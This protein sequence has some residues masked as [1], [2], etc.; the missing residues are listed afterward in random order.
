MSKKKAPKGAFHGLAGSSFAQKKKVVLGNVKHSG[1]KKDIFLSN[2]GPSNS[3]YSNIDSLSGN[4]KN[5]GMA[6]VHD[7]SLLGLAVT[8]S[9]AKHININAVFGSSLGSPDFTIDNNEIIFK[10]PVEVSVKK[11]FALNIDI[12]A[13]EGKSV[14]A[15]TQLVR[16]NFSTINGFGEAT[17]LSKFEEIIR[18][19]FTSE[20]SMNMTTLLARKK[21]IS[22]NTDLKKQSIYSDQ[23]VVIKEIPMDMPKEM[24]IAVVSKFGDIKSIRVQLIGMW[25]KAI[26]EFASSDQ[27]EQL[28]FRWSFLIGKNF[29]HASR[30]QFRTLLFTL[31][32]RTMAHDLGT[33]LDRAGGKTCV[34]NYSVGTGNKIRCAVIG[35]E[36]EEDLESAYCIEPIFSGIKLSWARID[37]VWCECCGKFGHSVLKCDATITSSFKPVKLFKKSTSEV[38]HLR[39]VKLYAKKNVSISHSTAFGNRSWAQ[40]VLAASTSHNHSAKAGSGPFPIVG[41][42]SNGKHSF[43]TLLNSS[44]NACLSTLECSLKLLFNQVSDIVKQLNGIALVS[45]TP[46]LIPVLFAVVDS[47][48]NLDMVLDIPDA[49]SAF[50]FPVANDASVLNSSNTRVLTSKVGSLES[51]LVALETSVGSVLGKLDLLCASLDIN[52]SAKQEDAIHWHKKSENMVL[53]IMET[54]LKLSTRPWIM[55]KGVWIFSSGLDKS[56]FGAGVAV[57]MNNSLAHHVSKVKEVSS[58]LILVW[59]LFKGKLL[60]TFVSLYAGVSTKVRFGLALEINSLIAKVVNSNSFVVLGEDF[61]KNRSKKNASNSRGTLKIIDFIF[62]S[63]NLASAVALHF[64]NNV[65]E[66]FDT[67]HKLISVLVGLGGLLDTCLNKVKNNS[68]LDVMWKVLS[69]TLVHA[70]DVVFFRHWFT[71]S[72]GDL[73]ESDQLVKIW[74]AVDIEEASKFFRLVLGGTSPSKLLK[75]LSIV[76][77]GYQKSKY[78]ESRASKDAVIKKAI[79]CCMENFCSDK[80]KII[81]SVLKYLFHKI[82]L[83]HLVVNNELVIEPS[84]IKLKSCQ[85]MLLDYVDDNVFTGVIKEIDMEEL[86]LVVGSLLN[87][88]TAGLL[89]IPNELWKHCGL[90]FIS[91]FGGIHEGRINK[92]MTNFGLSNGYKVDNGLDQGEVFFPFLWRIFYDSLLCEV[93]RH[94]HLCGYHINTW[95]VVRTGRV[96]TVG[97]KTSFLAAGVFVNDTIWVGSSQALTQYIL[98]IVSVKDASLLINGLPISIAKKGESHRYLDIFLSMKGLFKPSLAQVHKDVSSGLSVLNVLDSNDFSGVHNSLLDVWLDHVEV[99]TNGSLK[100]AGFAEVTCE[101]AAYFLAANVSIR[102]RVFGLLFSTLAELQAIALALECVPALCDVA[103]YSESQSDILVKWMKIKGHSGVLGNVKTDELANKAIASSFTLPVGIQ[104]QFL[105]AEGTAV[106]GNTHHF[107]CNI[108]HL[109]CHACWEAGPDYDVIPSVMLKEVDWVVTVNVWHPN[110]HMLFGFTN[111]KSANLHTYLMK[112]V[113]RQLPVVVKKRLYDKN[114]PGVLC[115]LC[116]KVELPDHVFTCSGNT[117]FRKEILVEAANKWTFLTGS[118]HLP[119]SIVLHLL[120]SCSLDVGLYAAICKGFVLKS[121]LIKATLVFKSKKKAVLALHRVDMEKA[122]LANDDSMVSGLSYCMGFL[123]SDRV[124]CMFGVIE[125]FAVSFNRHRLCHFFSGLGGDLCIKIDT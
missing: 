22:V 87:E 14:T 84:K 72:S 39:L 9:K 97:G 23:A 6:G 10:T 47:S 50:F 63:S 44:L 122:S 20:K 98:N 82:V 108:Y 38:T 48:V 21:G 103:L 110:S 57:I 19:I 35:F 107:V 77:K 8:I 32:I 85:Y 115:L 16:K 41:M 118:F 34:I 31:P 89:G 109:I 121:W 111:R 43:L 64:V 18:S 2:S 40:V 33:L 120:S 86:S 65:S 61:N 56:F 67:D 53:F 59:L 17:T 93:K 70:A 96:E 60:V 30:N 79:D 49:C 117:V 88:K 28:A 66:F 73:L 119:G 106:S 7:K 51:K 46:S 83:D 54:K 81:K 71:F 11:S 1:D 112:A 75:H 62:V 78:Y 25:Q 24:I 94:K 45:L 114:Y 113:H 100:G 92:V 123:L 68:D 95:F 26:V 37:L 124:V 69:E 42:N 36:S 12:S 15:K 58:H 99:Y 4:N 101:A 27:T 91:F 5:I 125:S 3:V 29:V 90:E 55:F 13:V 105:V 116:S 80:G 104:E 76:K 52:V 74:L 102:V